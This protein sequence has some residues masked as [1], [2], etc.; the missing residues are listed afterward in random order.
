M[1]DLFYFCA[2]AT[3]ILYDNE[4]REKLF[5]F[6]L[7]RPVADC[8]IGIT[9][10]RE[11]WELMLREKTSTYTTDALSALYPLNKED[12]NYWIYG[13]LLPDENLISALKQLPKETSLVF[14]NQ[15][16]IKRSKEFALDTELHKQ[17]YDKKPFLVKYPWEL[18]QKNREAI[19]RDY[20]LMVK[21]VAPPV[22]GKD[23]QLIGRENIFI[24]KSASILCSTINASTGPVYIGKNA[25]IMEG[26]HIRG[27]F[28]LGEG[29][30]VKMGT[31][32]YG[33]TTIGPYSMAGGEINNSIFFGYSNKAHD[34]YMGD[35]VLG[36]WCNWGAGTTCSNLKNTVQDF[37]IEVD[38]QSVSVG[39]KCGV[40]MGDFSRTAVQTKINSGTLV[41]VSAHLSGSDFPP[42]KVP[43]FYWNQS[44]KYQLNK[45]FRDADNW[46]RLKG[47]MLTEDLKTLLKY[48]HR[49]DDYLFKL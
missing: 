33:A 32:I 25:L 14:N 15:I 36:E 46:M 9:T 12:D 20:A 17:Q 27:P 8:R 42:K 2:V 18:F 48:I 16:L 38:G 30:V 28:A 13:G 44:E 1:E 23:V 11:K 7:T 34:G 26:C 45:A 40:M 41:G 49:E 47:K 19:E 4:E 10:I 35:S 43:S 21:Q 5:P 39:K 37:E 6:T 31:K 24:E 3:Y 29:A 22:L